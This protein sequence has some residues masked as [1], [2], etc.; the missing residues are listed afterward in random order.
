M[1]E[2]FTVA[3]V[4]DQE[5]IA[6]LRA[7]P[8]NIRKQLSK[9]VNELRLRLEQKIKD[10]KLRGGVLNY[11]TGKLYG[12]IF[13]GTE[14]NA[15]T[16]MGYAA[17]DASKAPYGR[18]HEEGGRTAAHIIEAVNGSALKFNIGGKTVFVKKVNHP[19]S[20]MPERS[21]MRSSLREM[22]QEIKQGLVETVQGGVDDS[23]K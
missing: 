3:L 15:T 19:G 2:A 10:E 16:I 13:S 11:R 9:K 14:E 17:Q 8:G 5:V 18:I 7:M 12:S 4:G 22:M 23:S 1:D 20:T 6:H 21:Y